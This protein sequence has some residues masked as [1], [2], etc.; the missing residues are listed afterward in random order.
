VLTRQKTLGFEPD[1]SVRERTLNWLRGDSAILLGV[2]PLA[3]QV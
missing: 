3:D 1:P 2:G